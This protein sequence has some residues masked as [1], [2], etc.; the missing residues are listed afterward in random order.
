MD[1]IGNIKMNQPVNSP[2]L[3]GNIA[4]STKTEQKQITEKITTARTEAPNNEQ[5]TAGQTN[6]TVKSN[7]TN[8]ESNAKN[9][10]G[11]AGVKQNQT[12]G[13]QQINQQTLT[14]GNVN[15]GNEVKQLTNISNRAMNITGQTSAPASGQ[16]GTQT[17]QQQA[18]QQEALQAAQKAQQAAQEAAQISAKVQQQTQQAQQQTQQQIQ[19][20]ST[21]QVQTRD[22]LGLSGIGTGAQQMS[23]IGSQQSDQ[24]A[25]SVQSQSIP[26]ERYNDEKYR[27]KNREDL[28]KQLLKME[29][30]VHEA[31]ATTS[32][33][34]IQ[35][36]Q[37]LLSKE[38]AT[39]KTT[40]QQAI[41]NA[42]QAQ[43]QAQQG[44]Q[45]AQEA[46]QQAQ[47][48]ISE[49]PQVIANAK[50]EKE[51]Q[52]AEQ[53]LQQAQQQSEMAQ[54]QLQQAGQQMSESTNQAAVAESQSNQNIVQTPPGQ[55]AESQ[56][57]I[58]SELTHID[59]LSYPYD[60][61][62][63]QTQQPATELQH[64]NLNYGTLNQSEMTQQSIFTQNSQAVF[65]HQGQDVQQ[66]VQSQGAEAFTV[67]H[68]NAFGSQP[69]QSESLQHEVNHQLE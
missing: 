43:Q 4:K 21:P 6:G 40:P 41:Q 31:R 9:I 63:L 33:S 60:I 27:L 3:M 61:P 10:T 13:N 59:S 65:P 42:Q 20:L 52:M 2:V 38:Q 35:D 69:L 22:G 44:A 49:L 11:D 32:Q 48:L 7:L 51:R 28:Q 16:E 36:M 56:Q 53:Q 34:V 47:K 64:E 5:Y 54:Q 50:T 1:K 46:L 29:Q 25:A 17:A 39:Q 23:M 30:Q 68:D 55:I 57:F 19:S 37:S 45:N 8:L 14:T 66:A 12:T 58:N 26:Y 24:Q 15:A 67:G 62:S 18:K